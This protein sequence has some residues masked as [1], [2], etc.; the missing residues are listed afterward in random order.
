MAPIPGQN[1]GPEAVRKPLKIVLGVILVSA[2][3]GLIAYLL[4]PPNSE[5]EHAKRSS[6]DA[7]LDAGQ[8]GSTGATK[9][10]VPNPRDL[11]AS[12]QTASPSRNPNDATPLPSPK[13][14]GAT[15]EHRL[16]AALVQLNLTNGPLNAEKLAAWQQALQR[17]AGSGTAAVPAIR[18]FLQTKQDMTF[19]SI[20]GSAAVGQASMRLAL[21]DT[22]FKIGSPESTVVLGEAL[23]TTTDPREI[24]ILARNLEKQSP[25]E[26]AQPAIDSARAAMAEA[27]AGKGRGNAAALF[28]VFQEYGGP[29]VVPD[30]V[31]AKDRWAYYSSIALGGLPDGSGVSGLVQIAQNTNTA[32]RVGRSAALQVLAQMA[33][34]SPDAR[35]ALLEQAQAGQIHPAIWLKMSAL[36]GGEQLQLGGGPDSGLPTNPEPRVSSYHISGGNQDFYTTSILDKLSPSQISDRIQYIDQLL[37]LKPDPLAVEGLQRARTALSGRVKT[38]AP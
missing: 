29:G 38:G 13:P 1:D 22:L 18:E 14:V 5:T 35:Q 3:G 30:L 2:V 12:S 7:R 16:V 23:R 27:I 34:D 25:G 32:A 36:L 17:L 9:S 8:I 19:E 6:S 15:D 4:R 37:A 28:S 33:A 26:Y 10:S 11:A 31:E 21:I 24:A 20:G